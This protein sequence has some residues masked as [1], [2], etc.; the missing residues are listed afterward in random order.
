MTTTDTKENI[1]GPL[2]GVRVLDFCSFINGAYSASLMGD[3]GAD[4]IK[5]EPPYGDL[6]RGWGPFIKGESR[7]YQTWNRSKRSISLDLTLPAAREIVY[8][9]TRRADVVIENFRPGV[10]EKLGIDYHTLREINSRIIYCSSTAFGS[11]GPYRDRPGYDPILQSLSGLANETANYAGRVAI[12]P[13]AASDYQA[14]MLVL[15]GVLAALFHR[16]STGEGQRIETSLL[17]GI[18]SIQTHFFY[19]PLEADPQ[20]RPGIYPYRLFETR[21]GQIF[22]GGATDKFWRMLCEVLGLTDLAIDP[23]YDTNEKRTARSTE[24]APILEPLLR[25]KTTGEWQTILMGKGIPCGAVGNWAAFFEDPQVEAMGMNQQIDHSLIGP[26][27]VTGVPINFEKT[28]GKIQRAAP[29][30]GEHT[31]E[32]LREL[33]YDD[34]AI[35][36]LRE[37]KMIRSSD[38]L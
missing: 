33:G 12:S 7:P 5:V 22:I 9:L 3:L 1:S 16:E 35:V 19:Q 21:D 8:A 24:L 37:G 4:V 18:M 28:P 38:H 17:Q 32:V 6:A 23:R 25:E 10:A 20:G 29:M 36:D 11:T 26:A 2:V 31:E 27:R 14:S 30:L 13:V 34:Q 15:T